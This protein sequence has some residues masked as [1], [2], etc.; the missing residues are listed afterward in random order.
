MFCFTF[1]KAFTFSSIKRRKRHKLFARKCGIC[2]CRLRFIKM[3]AC[4]ARGLDTKLIVQN[5][6]RK[7][8]NLF[9]PCTAARICCAD[10]PLKIL[11]LPLKI[12][13]LFSKSRKRKREEHDSVAKE[14]ATH[15]RNLGPPFSFSHAVPERTEMQKSC[16]HGKFPTFSLIIQLS[17]A[18]AR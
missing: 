15:P 7:A 17:T 14:I 8:L 2:V 6:P 11:N 12:L 9:V 13:T 4:A 10:L 3:V 5:S 16:L 18:F 1:A